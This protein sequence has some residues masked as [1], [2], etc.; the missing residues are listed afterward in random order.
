VGQTLQERATQKVT[1]MAFILAWFHGCFSAC[2]DDLRHSDLK[3]RNSLMEGKHV[4][5]ENVALL[6]ATTGRAFL[7]R[8][9]CRT[10]SRVSASSLNNMSWATVWPILQPR[11]EH[12]KLPDRYSHDNCFLTS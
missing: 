9:A 10:V 7:V 6:S 12:E 1:S 11:Y 5:S 4:L 2:F 8:L 3:T